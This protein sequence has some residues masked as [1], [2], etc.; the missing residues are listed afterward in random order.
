MENL[1]EYMRIVEQYELRKDELGIFINVDEKRIYMQKSDVMGEYAVVEGDYAG[2]SSAIVEPSPEVISVNPSAILVPME[3]AP[4]PVVEPVAE[5]IVEPVTEEIPAPMPV[6]EE[7]PA[8]AVEEAL[9]VEEAPA[10]VEEKRSF[11]NRRR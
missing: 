7:A 8:P 10:Q 9:P 3:P 1:G 4:Q 6:V 5:L 2:Y 11:S